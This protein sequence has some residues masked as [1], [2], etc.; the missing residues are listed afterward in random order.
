M[1]FG[2]N[3]GARIAFERKKKKLTQPQISEIVGISVNTVNRLEKGHRSPDL[4]ELAKFGEVLECD[5]QKLLFGDQAESF[6]AEKSVAVFDGKDVTD[7]DLPLDRQK[8]RFLLPGH[9]DADCVIKMNGDSM[10]PRIGDGDLL[11]IK[12]SDSVDVGLVAFVDEW[13]GFQ[14]RWMRRINGQDVFV[15]ENLE[16][17]PLKGAKVKII[18]KVVASVKVASFQ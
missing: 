15:P 4:V 8:G 13:G 9:E 16:Y 11:V 7:V 3:I 17:R 18:G 5:V 10:A 12:R 1:K 6:S 2:D 14:V